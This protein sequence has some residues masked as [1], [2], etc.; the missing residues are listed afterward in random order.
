MRM[1]A[2]GRDLRIIELA[3]W[4]EKP[5]NKLKLNKNNQK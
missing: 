5:Y 4:G 2:L 1:A 3:F